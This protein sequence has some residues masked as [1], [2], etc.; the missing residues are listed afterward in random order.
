MEPTPVYF[1]TE[2]FFETNTGNKL[3]R[4][5]I[6]RGPD[7]IE[8]GGKSIFQNACI[9]RG[10]LAKIKFGKYFILDEACIIKPSYK[11]SS[12]YKSQKKYF[13]IE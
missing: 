13:E 4:K 10:D 11:K 12:G 6:I 2:K 3:G 5:C 9:V 8:L 7:Q 1:S